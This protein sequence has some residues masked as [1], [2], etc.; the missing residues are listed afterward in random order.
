MSRKQ[1]KYLIALDLDGTLLNDEKTIS[2]LNQKI[3]TYLE[4]QGNKVVLCSGRALRSV[5]YYYDILNLKHSPVITYNGHLVKDLHDINFPEISYSLNQNT[6]KLIYKELFEK[7]LI[8]SAM[9]ESLSTIYCDDTEDNFLFAFYDT[10]NMVV[11]PGLLHETIDENVFT[12]VFKYETG[13]GHEEKI[14]CVVEKFPDVK[15]RF[16]FGGNY[17]ELYIEDVSKA[18]AIKHVAKYYGIPEDN[19]YAFGDSDNDR[20]M[21]RELKNSYLMKNGNPT[22][23]PDAKHITTYTNNDDGVGVELI[24]I[25]KLKI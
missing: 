10:K 7:K 19:I 22:L 23:I 6:V 24:K 4:N 18:R 16:W 15:V 14:K 20:E 21:L 1:A 12:C 3:L 11:K 2:P 17:C 8:T 25:F 9:S 5:S 13:H